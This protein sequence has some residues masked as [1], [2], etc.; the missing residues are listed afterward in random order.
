MDDPIQKHVF[1]TLSR[2]PITQWKNL[3]I[4]VRVGRQSSNSKF[5]PGNKHVYDTLESVCTD[6]YGHHRAEY[7]Q[8]FAFVHMGVRVEINATTGQVVGSLQKQSI[9]K[10]SEPFLRFSAAIE[11]NM[12]LPQTAMQYFNTQH[13]WQS[14][15]QG[16]P[17]TLKEPARLQPI[18]DTENTK[19]MIS[20]PDMM[21]VLPFDMRLD[22]PQSPPSTLILLNLPCKTA[23][24]G[25]YTVHVFPQQCVPISPFVSRNNNEVF[26][27]KERTKIVFARGVELHLTKTQQSRNLT[28]IHLNPQIYEVELEFAVVPI[29]RRICNA[30]NGRI[31][32]VC[33]KFNRQFVT[34]ITSKIPEAHVWIFACTNFGIPIV[35]ALF[36]DDDHVVCVHDPN[37][38][39]GDVTVLTRP[40][41]KMKDRLISRRTLLRRRRKSRYTEHC[42]GRLVDATTLKRVQN[43]RQQKTQRKGTHKNYEITDIK[44]L[45]DQCTQFEMKERIAAVVPFIFQ[46][47]TLVTRDVRHI[48]QHGH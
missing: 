30:S 17:I 35:E 10:F 22:A 24:L 8:T 37:I 11:A 36:M 39:I 44:M 2:T 15:L 3:E 32:I 20:L 31:H 16:V 33:D 43:R 40:L 28:T 38:L 9:M 6:L 29:I 18:D 4:E 42:D 13:P 5:F 46:L 26:R 7:M 41:Q 47:A 27:K 19:E 23:A 45:T 21:F 25:E 14:M 1:N 34:H 48:L 12:Q